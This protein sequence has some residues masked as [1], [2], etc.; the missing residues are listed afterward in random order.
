MNI[1]R[2]KWI[3]AFV[4][5]V[6]IGAFEFARHHFLNIISMDW[7]NVMVAGLTG[8]LFFI[9]FHGV[10]ALLENLYGKLQKEKEETA[11]LQERYRIARELHD[12]VAQALFF[13]NIKITEIETALRN[14]RQPLAEV[15]E[16]KEAIKLTDADIRQHIFALQNV[17]RENVNLLSAIRDYLDRYEKE[18]GVKVRLSTTGDINARLSS[19]VKNKLFHIF[20]ELLLNIRK[21]AGAEQVS[22]SLIEDGQQFSMIIRDNGQGFQLKNVNPNKSS[23]GLKILEDDVRLIG[24]RL[25]LESSP[26]QGTAAAV[27]LD[28]QEKVQE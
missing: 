18:S 27:S 22:V 15:A 14:R 6:F 11:V 28:L 13:M 12:S 8:V 26:G 16:M 1:S 9:Y 25:E 5:A 24:A 3:S 4:P 23:F 19:Y 2:M 10:F 21:H 7:G 20:Q 17:P